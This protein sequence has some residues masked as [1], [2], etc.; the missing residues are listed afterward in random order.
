MK[1]I[2]TLF[3]L[4]F[5]LFGFSACSN[6]SGSDDE[7]EILYKVEAGV[8]SK[9]TYNSAMSK[10]TTW[11]YVDYSKISSLRLYLYNNTV[12]DHEVKTGIKLSEIKDFLISHGMSTYETNQE[13]EVLKA[14]GNDIAFFETTYGSDKKS[15]M[16]ATK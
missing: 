15:W 9:E 10:I 6:N 16:Y 8:I 4:L 1:K 12:S 2:A 11:T 13:I 7:E 3:F 14:I 5:V